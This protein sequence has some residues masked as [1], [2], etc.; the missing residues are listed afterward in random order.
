MLNPFNL[1]KWIYLII[2]FILYKMKRLIQEELQHY[3]TQYTEDLK[4]DVQK[5]SHLTGNQDVDYQILMKLNLKDLIHYCSTNTYINNTCNNK[6]FWIEKI[7]GDG[8][9]P[10]LLLYTPVILDAWFKSYSILQDATKF[11]SYVLMIYDIELLHV[12]QH[13]IRIYGDDAII[14]NI[15][16]KLG[17]DVIVQ[18]RYEITIVKNNNDEYTFTIYPIMS[19]FK[20]TKNQVLN[21]L[22]MF[23]SAQL[24]GVYIN[25]VD[26]DGF[27]YLVPEYDPDDEQNA[28]TL[29]RLGIFY[30]F[31][32]IY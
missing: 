25:I 20:L 7:K 1:E 8:L 28:I 27:A 3:K 23:I 13:K 24:Y 26:V 11:A 2:N 30:A 4:M 21:L 29:I 22:T 14:Y 17:Y 16:R 12:N 9:N 10:D 19:Q 18:E 5:S 6:I 15:I 32:H 31:Q